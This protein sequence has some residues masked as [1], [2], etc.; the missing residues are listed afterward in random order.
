MPKECACFS[1]CQ[2]LVST[3]LV[4]VLC[5]CVCLTFYWRYKKKI[6]EHYVKVGLSQGYRNFCRF[7]QGHWNVWIKEDIEDMSVGEVLEVFQ[8][9]SKYRLLHTF[10]A[11]MQLEKSRIS[12]SGFQGPY[13]F[14][15]K[16]IFFSVLIWNLLHSH[17]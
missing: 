14:N 8:F 6:W 7:T 13:L 16:N 4:C 5:V 2:L 12:G 11:G 10:R 15:L 17:Y 1:F 9:V 3:L